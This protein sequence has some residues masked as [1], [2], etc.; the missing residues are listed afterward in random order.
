M[1]T[2]IKKVFDKIKEDIS[3]GN[4]VLLSGITGNLMAYVFKYGYFLYF[5]IPVSLIY[6]SLY[7]AILYS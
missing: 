7:D 1:K 2:D 3:V 4:I 6:I 5:R